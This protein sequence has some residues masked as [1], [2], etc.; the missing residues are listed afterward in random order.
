LSVF[1]GLAAVWAGMKLID[2]VWRAHH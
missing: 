1:G 2:L